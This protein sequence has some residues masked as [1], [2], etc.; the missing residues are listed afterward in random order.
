MD[1]LQ[2]CG[3]WLTGTERAPITFITVC[4]DAPKRSLRFDAPLRQT[5]ADVPERSS[6]FDARTR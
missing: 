4:I 3:V 5:S 6:D 2:L 1:I